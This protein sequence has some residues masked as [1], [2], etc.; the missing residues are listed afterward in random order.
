MSEHN[1]VVYLGRGNLNILQQTNDAGTD[2]TDSI[3]KLEV[4]G[5]SGGHQPITTERMTA[6]HSTTIMFRTGNRHRGTVTVQHQIG[7]VV[8]QGD[9]LSGLDDVCLHLRVVRQNLNKR[10]KVA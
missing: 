3:A 2:Y 7:D 6:M 4:I 8:V 5:V 1:A 9:D 10:R